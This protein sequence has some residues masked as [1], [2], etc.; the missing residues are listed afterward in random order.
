MALAVGTIAP[1]FELK[2]QSG[3][4]V[5]LSSFKG[6][7]NVVLMFY[8]FSFTGTCTGELCEIRDNLDAFQSDDV[9][10]LAISCDSPFVQKVFAERENYKFPVLSDFWPHGA[11]AR[12]YD[13]FVEER[14]CALRGTFVIDMNG[15]IRWSVV[16][17]LGEARD[18]V[19]YRKA[20]ADL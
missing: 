8:P 18:S 12:S 6:V 7:K 13:V 19:E 16:H 1:D 15:V 17:G 3:N 20:L 2:D 9:Q 5:S 10:V 11:V 14:G 4:T